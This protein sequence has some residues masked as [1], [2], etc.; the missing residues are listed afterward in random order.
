MIERINY[1]YKL[2]IHVHGGAA[3]KNNLPALQITNSVPQSEPLLFLVFNEGKTHTM[4]MKAK[5]R[6]TNRESDE[7]NF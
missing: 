2:Q 6:Q 5:R 1:S 3:A 7:I 4:K